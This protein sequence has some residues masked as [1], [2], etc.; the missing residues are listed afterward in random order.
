MKNKKIRTAKTIPQK[1]NKMKKAVASTA[2]FFFVILT[3][4]PAFAAGDDVT[5]VLTNLSNLMFTIIRLVG[6]V[7]SGFSLFQF[8]TAMKSH[9]GAQKANSGLGLAAGLLI[10]FAKEILQSIGVPIA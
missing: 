1:S 8:A 3:A 4:I 2:A 7:I 10:I 5:N 6:I 9:D